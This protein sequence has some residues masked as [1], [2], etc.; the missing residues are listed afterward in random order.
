MKFWILKYIWRLKVWNLYLKLQILK[1][2]S[3][4]NF[5]MKFILKFWILK[6]WNTFEDWRFEIYIWILKF[7]NSFQNEISKMKFI[8][9]FWILKFWDTFE[10]WRFE[11]YIWSFKFW[12]S[13]QNEISKWNSF[14]I[15]NFEILKYIW[16]LKVWNL[17]LKLEIL[18]FISKWNFNN[19]I[20]FEILNFEIH[21]KIEGLKF[22]FEASCPFEGCW[23]KT[24]PNNQQ[25]VVFP[26]KV[27]GLSRKLFTNKLYYSIIS[28]IHS[29]V[30][31]L[32]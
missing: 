12:N 15:L 14:E 3:K 17:H 7:W 8:L 23:Q 25:K 28:V 19:E 27:V 22:T 11:I 2:I 10:D 6:F 30:L 18:K 9:K 32:L 29:I 1:F 13:F 24:F 16:R 5:K 26:T 4:W 21:L 31:C 20:H